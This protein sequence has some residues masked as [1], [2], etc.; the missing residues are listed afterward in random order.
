MCASSRSIHRTTKS[1]AKPYEDIM[2]TCSRKNC[3]MR[4]F[5]TQKRASHRVGFIL[6]TSIF[7]VGESLFCN[8]APVRDV[9]LVCLPPASDEADGDGREQERDQFRNAAQTL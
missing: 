8:D 1:R 4:S 2:P 9:D 6:A 7:F 5:L 3:P